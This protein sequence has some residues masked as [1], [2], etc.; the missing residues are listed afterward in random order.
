MDESVLRAM[1]RWPDVP[2]V[3][4]WLSL[5]RR[6]RWLIRGETLSNRAALAFIGRNYTSDE[7]GCWHF[8]NGPQRVFVALHYT[9]W[10][11]RLHDDGRLATHTGA[12]AA[13]RAA[14]M[15]ERGAVLIDTADGVGLLDDR[16][17]DAFSQRLC[18]ADGGALDDAAVEARVERLGAGPADLAVRLDGALLP[19]TAVRSAEV[20]ARFGFVANPEPEPEAGQKA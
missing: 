12:A 8:Q 20:P 15:D 1:A 3:Y 10:V 7:R 16:D 11:L 18:A 13:P 6:G 17:L 5:D 4:G 2:A 14:A 19:L 9:P